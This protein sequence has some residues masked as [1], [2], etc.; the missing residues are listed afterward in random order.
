MLYHGLAPGRCLIFYGTKFPLPRHEGL[1]EMLLEPNTYVLY[2]G[3]KARN[4]AEVKQS[5]PPENKSYNL[6]LIDGTWKQAKSMYFQSRM[7]HSLPQVRIFSTN[8]AVFIKWS[9]R[10]KQQFSNIN[11][12][13][14]NLWT[15]GLIT[16]IGKKSVRDQ[17]SA[18]WEVPLNCR[19]GRPRHIYNGGRFVNHGETCVPAQGTVHFSNQARSGG[20]PGQGDTHRAR[21]V[22]QA[23]GQEDG[24]IS[25][26]HSP[27][28]CELRG[29]A[30]VTCDIPSQGQG[31]QLTIEPPHC[32]RVYVNWALSLIKA[33][34]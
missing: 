34:F 11:I 3:K 29:L 28:S 20:A 4:I 27:R 22:P 18:L 10:I 19:I 21:A 9:T 16:R 15:I 24:E 23:S 12:F 6:I 7:L 1:K 30:I 26:A 2:P 33:W 31:V 25:Q 8:K 13:S 32:A 17:N 14:L 5:L